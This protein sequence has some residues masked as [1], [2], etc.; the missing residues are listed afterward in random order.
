MYPNYYHTTFCQKINLLLLY[1]I[2]IILLSCCSQKKKTIFTKKVT[3]I[4]PTLPHNS[5]FHSNTID[6]PIHL[7]FPNLPFIILPD[8]PN[9]RFKHKWPGG[10]YSCV[11]Q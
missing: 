4:H 8:N 2:L 6:Q 5:K 10:Y 11:P 9:R 7:I 3:V 1:V